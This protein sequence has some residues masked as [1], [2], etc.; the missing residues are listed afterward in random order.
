VLL[1]LALALGASPATAAPPHAYRAARLWTGAGPP[2]ADGVL[3]VRD[4]K[5]VAAGPRDKVTVPDDAEVH[6]LGS[7][8]LIPGLVIAETTL[9]E[10]DRDDEHA[11]TPDF[12]AL[13]GFDFYA[14]YSRALAGGV[15]TVQLAPVGKGLMPGQGSVVKLA[16]DDP[17][18]RTLRER[19]SLRVLLGEVSR[20][21]PRIYEP[22]VGA[23]S[24]ERPLEPTRHQLSTSLAGAVAGLRAT[25]RAAS[26]YEKTSAGRKDRDAVMAAVAE[27]L[28]PGGTVRIT[29][30]ESSDLRAALALARE[31][32]LRL[33]LV[34]PAPLDSFREQ[35][36]GWRDTVAGVVLNTGVRPGVVPEKDDPKHR[37]PWESARALLAAGYKVALRPADDD[38]LDATLFTAGLLTGR[39]LSA[40]DV[41][42][43]LTA[44]PA[45]LLGV[46]DRVGTLAPG[47]DADFVV[48]SG[49]PFRAHSRV[50][51]V[52]VDGRQVAGAARPARATV[53]RASRVY[54]GTGDVIPGGAVLVEGT[55]VRAVGRDVSAPPDAVLRRYD[56][57]VVVPGFLDLATGVGERLARGDAAVTAARQGGV[58]TL[59]LASSSSSPSPVVAFKVGDHPRAV[60]GPVAVRFALTGNLTTQAASLRAT[61][62]GAR[63]Y[64]ETWTRYDAALAEYEKKKQEY[65]A[66]RAKAPKAEEKKGDA[67]AKKDEPKAPAA[68]EK[69]RVVENMEPYRLLF[70]GKA[71]ALVEARRADAIKLAVQIFR[72][73][74][75]VRTVLLGAED[76]F[77]LGDLLTEKQVAVAVGPDMLVP[78]E[79]VRATGPRPKRAT[80]TDALKPVQTAEREAINLAQV[81]AN[82]GV[83]F[84]FQSRGTTSV[85]AL[86]LAVQYAVY[87]GLGTD[88]A[89]AGLTAAPA[90]LLSLD[91]RLGT[92]AAGRDADLV[93][94]SGPPFELSS[95]VLAVMVDGQ[96]VYQDEDDR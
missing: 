68:P 6:D 62:Q 27:H 31:F 44:T 72:D 78:N 34:D 81:L 79:F 48:L 47:K 76:A 7:A 52:Y 9:A 3:V 63:A 71:P 2:I 45:E 26:E 56:H 36:P 77:R 15:T 89:L 18:A 70:A 60:P 25:F 35:L 87:R 65:E 83:P 29:A 54:T 21:P 59:L 64:A 37:L 12:R 28:K 73:E 5:I 41:L 74:F 13:D 38:D 84:G 4:G 55:T 24:V 46:A 61:L 94:L 58:T 22:P 92:L 90:K 43:M 96:W 33:L 80:D 95:R 49:E 1:G 82:R 30:P 91:G 88:D 39:G 85:K 51:A 42:R 53:I 23:V 93:V 86:P 57:A 32:K 16:G 75:K 8:V 10:R 11:L 50:E 20:K 19:E 17:T 40:Q 66:T 69:P 67:P 14:D